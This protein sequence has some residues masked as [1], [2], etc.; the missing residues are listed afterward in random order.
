[1][2]AP[3][4]IVVDELG[5]LR[6]QSGNNLKGFWIDVDGLQY[7]IDLLNP[8]KPVF[9]LDQRE[10]HALVGSLCHDRRVLDGFAGQGG[11]ALQAAQA[12]ARAVVAVDLSDKAAKTLGANAQK[13][14]FSVQA[15]EADLLSY[16]E[17]AEASA[18]DAVILDPPEAY[19]FENF[20]KLLME[21]FRVLAQG[22]L[23]AVY[24]RGMEVSQESFE[25]LISRAASAQGREGRIFAKTGQP[26]DFPSLLSLPESVVLKGLILQ[27]E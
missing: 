17:G 26:F 14:G 7:R 9:Y 8:A 12:G 23:L 11:F 21:V 6:T 4:E 18:F 3:R 24:S 22:G 20:E 13:N 27:V 15:V 5:T 2:V 1:L 10:Q 16:L 19:S 25:R